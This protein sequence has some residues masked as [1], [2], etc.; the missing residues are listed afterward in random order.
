MTYWKNNK[1]YGNIPYSKPK[2]NLDYILHDKK[3]SKPL[4]IIPHENRTF[5]ILKLLR[6]DLMLQCRGCKQ[7]YIVP[8]GIGML[9]LQEE[10]KYCDDCYLEIIDNLLEDYN[11]CRYNHCLEKISSNGKNKIIDYCD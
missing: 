11:Y 5:K 10:N 7:K 9:H 6:R 1:N 2:F 4:P 3:Y 8:Y